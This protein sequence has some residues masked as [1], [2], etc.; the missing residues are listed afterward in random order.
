MTR[1]ALALRHLVELG[2]MGKRGRDM[3]HADLENNV[4]AHA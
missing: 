2:G 3:T 1:A 4:R